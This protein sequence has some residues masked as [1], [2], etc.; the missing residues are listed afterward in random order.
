MKWLLCLVLWSQ[1]SHSTTVTLTFS[2]PYQAPNHNQ[3]VMVLRYAYEQLEIDFELTGLPVA[4]ALQMANQGETDGE[5]SRIT[6]L[7]D[8]Y[9]NLIQIPVAI[10]QVDINL[11]RPSSDSQLAVHQWLTARSKRLGCLKGIVAIAQYATKHGL[12]CHDIEEPL[13]GLNMILAGNID[14]FI[15][16]QI[17]TKSYLDAQTETV[18]SADTLTQ[19]PMYHYLH[20]KHQDLAIRLTEVLT[21]MQQSGSIEQLVRETQASADNVQ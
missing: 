6:G 2:Y 15:S 7:T 8:M 4:R 11:Y 12:R 21:K 16:P 10:N 5:L 17:L 13:N 1:I 19:L 18:F 14:G 3:S 9:P 20:K